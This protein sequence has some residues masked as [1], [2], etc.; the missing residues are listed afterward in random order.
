M[1]TILYVTIGALCFNGRKSGIV[2]AHALAKPVPEHLYNHRWY[3]TVDEITTVTETVTDW[4]GSEG[5]WNW[6]APATDT[7]TPPPLTTSTCCT[8]A[9]VSST[10][11]IIST[12]GPSQGTAGL[13]AT[14][15]TEQHNIHRTN[16]SVPPLTWSV[17]MANIAAQ[18]ALNC[19]YAHNT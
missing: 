12:A 2:I 11:S 1:K 15:I 3:T 9:A 7:V 13:N 6:P 10:V 14:A 16:A 18:I 4:A 17:E 19:I 8:P 5:S